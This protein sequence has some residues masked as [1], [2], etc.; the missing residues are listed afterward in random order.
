MFVCCFIKCLSYIFFA[1][2]NKLSPGRPPRKFEAA[3]V[4]TLQTT[5]SPE[6]WKV[7]CETAVTLAEQGD[8]HARSW[9][10]KYLLPQEPPD[11]A[12]PLSDDDERAAAL[13]IL[14]RARA[15]RAALLA[16]KGN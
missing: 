4:G 8:R 16:T 15:G 7:I 5:C 3:Y 11:V 2:G 12:T 10:S 9:L 14:E 1:P 13:A 6:R